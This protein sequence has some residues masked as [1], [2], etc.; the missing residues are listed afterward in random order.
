MP[1]RFLGARRNREDDAGMRGTHDM[2]PSDDLTYLWKITLNNGKTHYFDWTMFN[3]Y[4]KLPEG[5]VVWWGVLVTNCLYSI[6]Q[7]F[8]MSTYF[9]GRWLHWYQAIDRCILDLFLF[10]FGCTLPF[11]AS[12]FVWGCPQTAARLGLV[13]SQNMLPSGNLT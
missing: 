3:G 10:P 6:F 9:M 1:W 11:R 5:I 2:T 8:D 12:E 4:I 7:L 13:S